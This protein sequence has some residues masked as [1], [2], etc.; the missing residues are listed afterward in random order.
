[1]KKRK[2]IIIAGNGNPMIAQK[3]GRNALC[4]CGSGKK[5][6]HCH[7]AETKYYSKKTKKELEREEKERQ[8]KKTVPFD[9]LIKD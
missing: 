6:K 5:S 2:V 3:I 4:Y 7:N 8:S 1:M 9:E